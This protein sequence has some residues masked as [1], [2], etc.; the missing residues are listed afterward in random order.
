[1]DVQPDKQNIDQVFSNTVYYIDFY[2]RQYK[3]D[4]DPVN[5]LLEDVF[6]KF[7]EEDERH[8]NMQLPTDQRV[9]KYSWYYLNTYVTNKDEDT[10]RLYVVDGQQRLT[11]LTLILICLRH[12]AKNYDS[13][14]YDWISQK[15]SGTQGYKRTFWMN[16]EHDLPTIQALFDGVEDVPEGDGVTG[17]NMKSNYELISKRLQKELTDKD[18][19][20]RFVFFYLQRL[21]II[22]LNVE[23][24]DVP[25]VFEVINDRGV[26][27]K[28]YEILKGKLLGQIDKESLNAFNLNELWEKQV[29]SINAYSSEYTDEVDNFFIAFLR[30]KFSDTVSDSRKFDKGY[31]RSIFSNT[32]LKLDHNP[33]EVKRFLLEDFVYYTNLYLKLLNLSRNETDGFRHIFYNWLTQRDSQLRLILAACTLN[34]PQEDEKIKVVS[35]EIDRM[36]T[37]L[38]LQRCYGGGNRFNELSYI[39]GEKIRNKDI[40]SIRQ[41]FNDVLIDELREK[42]GVP[43]LSEPFNYAYFKDTGIDLEKKFKR[44]LFARVEQFIADNTSMNMRQNIYNLVANTGPVNGFHIEHIIAENEE[45]RHLFNDDLEYFNSQRNRLGGLLLLKGRDN[46]SSNNE[47][48]DMKLESYANTLYW[49]ESLRS[50]SYKSKLDFQQ[51]I[52]KYHLSFRPYNQFGPDELEERQ[53]L[54]Y[55]IVKIIWR[56]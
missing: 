55:S 41:V 49:N 21:V 17:K 2:Q 47:T 35:F 31:H 56:G 54:L 40:E 10:G 28:P 8:K 36:V 46:E 51:M 43:V 18:R 16:H 24:T 37:L 5:R 23:Q 38:Q 33:V 45:N 1:M 32:D 12:M 34:D 14:L 7:N 11:T 44:Y 29:N 42:L 26:R 25:M 22:Q 6:Y 39:I 4:K 20:E 50:D 52:D 3:W 13:A 19:F 30:S 9:A 53:R 48:F 15:I 27:L